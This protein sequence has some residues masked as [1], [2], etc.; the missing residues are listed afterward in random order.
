MTPQIYVR[1]EL[2]DEEGEQLMSPKE[3]SWEVGCPSIVG[4]FE[5]ELE[6]LVEDAKDYAILPEEE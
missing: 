5:S 1:I 4:D 6:Q 3:I 2:I